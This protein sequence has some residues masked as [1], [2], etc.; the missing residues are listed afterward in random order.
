MSRADEIELEIAELR[1]TK[2][3]FEH[4]YYYDE[5]NEF[6]NEIHGD[7]VKIAGL[8]YDTAQ[9]LEAIDPVAYRCG[10][11]DYIDSEITR[12][13]DEIEELEGELL[14]IEEDE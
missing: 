11:D 9:T 5:Y 8:E 10:Y 4:G 14:E 1:E 3:E 12:I 2:K 6:L 7:T 13:D